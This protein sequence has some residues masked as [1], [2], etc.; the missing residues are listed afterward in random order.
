MNKE[1]NPVYSRTDT[2]RVKISN[3]EWQKVLPEDVYYIARQREPKDPGPA[4]MKIL[5][6]WA[7]IIAPP[8][9]TLCLRATPNLKAVA[10]GPAFMSPSAKP[11]LFTKK[12]KATAWYVQR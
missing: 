3:E 10:A 5:R 6:K 7:L 1:N 9:E 12:I 11:A 4:N 8:A 2:S